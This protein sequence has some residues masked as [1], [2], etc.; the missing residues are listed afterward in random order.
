VFE[1]VNDLPIKS[2]PVSFFYFASF[3]FFLF[4]FSSTHSLRLAVL[5]TV[6][7]FIMDPNNEKEE[8]QI[9]SDN[10]FA[11]DSVELRPPDGGRGW[12]VVLGSFFVKH[13]TDTFFAN[14]ILTFLFIADFA[15]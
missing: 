13:S 10:V 4:T 11:T 14:H 9:P 2:L 8:P 12:L 5:F 1:T 15:W 7:S 6:P 3:F